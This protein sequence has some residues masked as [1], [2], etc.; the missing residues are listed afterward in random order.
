MATR[1]SESRRRW[2]LRAALLGLAL[3]AA[4]LLAQDAA[5]VS[6]KVVKVKLDNDRV[7]V[8]EVVS[9]PGDKEAMHSHPAA[10]LYVVSGGT[11]RVSFPDGTK[12]DIEFKAGDT[13][14]RAPVTHTAENVGTT[15]VH[16]II[17]ELKKP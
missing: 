17:V 1:K 16:Q 5:L 6:P 11:L 10:V 2:L 7:R 3:G 4:A 12:R 9:K 14:F 13:M 8:L 15:A